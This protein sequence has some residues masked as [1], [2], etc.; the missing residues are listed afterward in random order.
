LRLNHWQIVDLSFEAQPRNPHSSPR[1]WC[2]PHNVTRSLDRSV[3][4]Y[5]TCAWPSP[6]LCIR[7]PTPTTILIATRHVA[8]V[9]YTPRD[10]QTWF[11]T[12]DKRVKGRTNESS[13]IRIQT[14]AS[15]LLI[16]IKPIN[17]PLSFS[18]SPLMSTL[19]TQTHKVWIL[20][21]RHMKHS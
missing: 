2:R 7:P 6:V 12:Q 16:T 3:T 9:T 1:V 13:R 17:W 8:P 14:E 4:E 11:F 20:N 5:P 19:T 15:Q 18:I 10:K 21:L